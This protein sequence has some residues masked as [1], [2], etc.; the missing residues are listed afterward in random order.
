MQDKTTNL[1]ALL[2]TT[3]IILTSLEYNHILSDLQ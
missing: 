3:T 1:F 2:Y